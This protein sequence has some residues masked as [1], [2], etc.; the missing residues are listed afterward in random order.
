MSAA[1][2]IATEKADIVSAAAPSAGMSAWGKIDLSMPARHRRARSSHRRQGRARE[3]EGAEADVIRGWVN[4]RKQR[5]SHN[6]KP[7][8]DGERR[9]GDERG[10]VA[11]KPE[12]RPGNLLRRRPAA[13]ERGGLALDFEHLDVLAG[14]LGLGDMKVGQRRAGTD[15][16]D[17]N[18]VHRFFEGERAGHGEDASLGRVVEAHAL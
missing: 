16:V 17:A 4:T 18:P 14:G 15:G 10:F 7:A 8:I 6:G 9:P 12:N 1:T 3:S 5:L 11:G 2:P 13:E